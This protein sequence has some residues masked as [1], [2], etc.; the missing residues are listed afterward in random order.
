MLTSINLSLSS[1]ENPAIMEDVGKIMPLL[2]IIAF[3]LFF[4]GFDLK[5]KNCR[6]YLFDK[7]DQ[8]NCTWK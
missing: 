8:R 6:L 3:L 4:L 5:K 2:A 1:S 7:F